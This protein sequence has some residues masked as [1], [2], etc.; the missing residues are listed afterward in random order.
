ML[1]RLSFKYKQQHSRRQ[2]KLAHFS[3]VPH[4]ANAFARLL[5][6]L[7]QVNSWFQFFET[8][9]K[10]HPQPFCRGWDQH[11]DPYISW[12]IQYPFHSSSLFTAISKTKFKRTVS[13][14]DDNSH[15]KCSVNKHDSAGN[16][17]ISSFI[18][19]STNN[20]RRS[21]LTE[22]DQNIYFT[23]VSMVWS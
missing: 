11:R 5:P 17:L 19:V 2:S 7:P 18:L 22:L 15:Q 20:V 21:P 13:H 4:Q 6:L 23:V 8:I 10:L 16:L 9:A 3:L 12:L 14:S 1:A